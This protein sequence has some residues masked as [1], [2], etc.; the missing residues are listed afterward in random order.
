CC[1]WDETHYPLVSGEK[2]TNFSFIRSNENLYKAGNGT[3]STS[4]MGITMQVLDYDAAK[5]HVNECLEQL[6]LLEKSLPLDL[7]KE[8]NRKMQFN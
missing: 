7:I 2:I 5:K 1:G 8:E 4:G 3:I 6:R